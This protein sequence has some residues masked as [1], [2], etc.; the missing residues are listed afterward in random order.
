VIGRLATSA[1]VLV[2]LV[3]GCSLVDDD[4]TV[5]PPP[6]P[7]QSDLD[8]MKSSPDTKYWVGESFEGHELTHAQHRPPRAYLAYGEPECDASSCSYDLEINTS[9]ARDIVDPPTCW[10]SIRRALVLACDESP[11]SARVLT[12]SVIVNIDFG[13]EPALPVVRSL[14][15]MNDRSELGPLPAPKPFTCREL[16]RIPDRYEK[17]LDRALMT[18]CTKAEQRALQKR[19]RGK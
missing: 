16:V 5:D 10:R 19:R 1:T 11:P 17:H 9:A 15:L 8:R 2:C 4:L 6:R 14:R 12:G 18:R 7:S 13:D 3:S